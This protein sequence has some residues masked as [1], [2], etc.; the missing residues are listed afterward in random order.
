MNRDWLRTERD[1]ARRVLQGLLDGKRAFK[2]DRDVAVRALRKWLQIDDQALL[3]ETHSYFSK[4]LEDAILPRP[5][6][7]QMVLDEVAEER[8]D[9]R[10]LRPDDLVDPTLAAEL[11]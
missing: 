3:E 1:T 8:P 2:H 11:R 5:E 7:L 6:G 10:S 9:A 4:V